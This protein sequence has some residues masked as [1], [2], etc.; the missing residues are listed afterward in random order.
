MCRG[1]GKDRKHAHG[2]VFSVLAMRDGEK[3]AK[4]P[5]RT[6]GGAFWLFGGRG[7]VKKMPN[8]KYMPL[9]AHFSSLAC[10]WGKK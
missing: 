4:Y 6:Q 5:K 2:D 9:R 8:T 3:D 7:R 1:D 10:G